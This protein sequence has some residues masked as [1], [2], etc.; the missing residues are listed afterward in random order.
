MKRFALGLFAL[1]SWLFLIGSGLPQAAVPG[2]WPAQ[3]ELFAD[4]RLLAQ[5]VPFVIA[6]GVVVGIFQARA[7]I[8][9]GGGDAVLGDRVRRHDGSTMMAHWLNAIG[10]LMCLI[11]GAM[12]LRWTDRALD[13]RMLF[14]LH[15]VGAAFML[16][17]VFNHL[18]RHGVAGGTALIPKSL[19]VISDTIGE[20]FEYAGFFGPEAAV[21]KLPIPKVIR[22]PVASYVRAILG[23]DP[24]KIGKY[25]PTEKLL[26]YTP[27]VIWIGAMIITGLVKTFKYVYPMPG[28]WVS[29]ATAVHDIVALI[30]GISIIIH[31]LPLSL[32]PANYPL[33][34]SMFKSTVPLKYVEERHPVWYKQLMARAQSSPPAAPATQQTPVA[35]TEPQTGD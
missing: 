7:A 20:L 5:G 28:D 1:L 15:Y 29:T 34:L 18:S 22:K 33:L 9:K 3:T 19:R 31:L 14:V 16:Y 27:W 13:L 2:G 17:A 24:K 35:R 12:V 26:S 32:V 8:L 21:L 30:V 23:Y 11:T 25:L 10:V 4:A 6:L